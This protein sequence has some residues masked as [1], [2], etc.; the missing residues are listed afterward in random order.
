MVV[1][2]RELVQNEKNDTVTALG[3]VQIYYKGKILEADKVIYDRK[4][5]RVF[6]EGKARLTEPNGQITRAERFELTDDLQKRFCR[7][8]HDRDQGKNLS[9]RAAC[10]AQRR[11]N[12]L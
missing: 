9:Q 8:P 6:A 5:S 3:N 1:E 10:R 11:Y 7:Q 12:R 4:T 2:A